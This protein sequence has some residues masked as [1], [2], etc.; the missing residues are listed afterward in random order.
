M[1]FDANYALQKIQL[2]QTFYDSLRLL[3]KLWIDEI[4]QE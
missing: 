3:I 2:N 4:G 1:K